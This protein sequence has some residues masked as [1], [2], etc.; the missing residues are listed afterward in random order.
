MVQR[1]IAGR[2]FWHILGAKP[3]HIAAF[4]FC[5]SEAVDAVCFECFDD[6]V[7]LGGLGR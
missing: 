5:Y 7:Y 2:D 6:G 4:V 1:V 3:E